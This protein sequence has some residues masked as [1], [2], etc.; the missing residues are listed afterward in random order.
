ME[1]IKAVIRKAQV[2]LQ[3][4]PVAEERAYWLKHIIH[5]KGLQDEKAGRENR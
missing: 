4:T 1:N 2:K 5:L 3:A